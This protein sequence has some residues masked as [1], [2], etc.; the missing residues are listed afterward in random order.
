MNVFEAIIQRRSHRGTFQERLIERDD[1]EKLI[2]AARWTPSPFNVQPWELV[3]IQETEGKV[4]LAELTERAVIDQFKDAQFLDDNS[5]WMRLTET[6]QQEQG[7]GVLLTE[8]VSLPKPLQNAPEKVLQELLKNAKS[9]TLLGHLGVGKIPA[10]EISMQ[11]REAPLLILVA[12]NCKRRPPG[13]GGTRWMWLSMGML[14]QNILLTATALG[15]GVQFVSAPLERPADREQVRQVFNI[16][17]FHE[18][19]TLLR[20]GYV[21]EETGNSVRLP[22]SKFVHFEKIK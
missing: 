18:V 2:E 7:D 22:T 15:V 16:P 3:L 4:V 6:E 11:V 10:K 19:I 1:L 5:R 21:E 17:V 12:M 9:F 13:E 8:H 20:L 14:I